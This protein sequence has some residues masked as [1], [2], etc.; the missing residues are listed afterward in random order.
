[1]GAPYA[2]AVSSGTAALHLA[3]RAVGVSEGGEVITSPFSFVATRGPC[4]WISYVF[5]SPF[6][7]SACFAGGTEP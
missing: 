2:S 1:V 6:G 5:H 4:T 3:L 7:F